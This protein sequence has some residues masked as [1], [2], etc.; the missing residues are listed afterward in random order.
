M[1][2]SALETIKAKAGK[3]KAVSYEIR[4][5][6]EDYRAE[7]V[8]GALCVLD[9]WRMCAL[10]SLLSS[11][12]TWME[13]KPE[14]VKIAEQLQLN[15]LGLLFKVPKSYPRS[16]LRSESG[17][18]LIKYQI[19]IAKLSLIFHIRNMGEAALAKQIYNQQ[20]LYGWLRLIRER[21]KLCEELGIPDVTKV[22]AS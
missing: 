4:A 17:L 7:I 2:T 15:F 16:A 8:C 6:I 19:L 10:P 9:L 3:I 12:S 13:V 1:S 20:L 18:L 11:C 14:A 5:I 22:K 21:V